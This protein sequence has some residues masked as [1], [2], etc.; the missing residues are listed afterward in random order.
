MTRGWYNTT[1]Y[2]SKGA[3]WRGLPRGG[4]WAVVLETQG[5]VVKHTTCATKEETEAIFVLSQK[6]IR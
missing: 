1:V 5:D 3:V 6:R 4:L 2:S